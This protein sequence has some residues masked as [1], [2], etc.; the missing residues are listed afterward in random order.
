ML[1]YTILPIVFQIV[2]WFSWGVTGLLVIGA[3]PNMGGTGY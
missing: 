1:E 3:G 2:K